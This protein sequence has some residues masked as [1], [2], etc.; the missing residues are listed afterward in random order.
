MMVGAGPPRKTKEFTSG[1]ELEKKVK[2]KKDE[3]IFDEDDLGATRKDFKDDELD[4]LFD[5]APSNP[6]EPEPEP[7]PP[8]KAKVVSKPKVKVKEPSP[9]PSPPPEPVKPKAKPKAKKVVKE[10]KKPS[11]NIFDDSDSDDMFSS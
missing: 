4:N 1:P 11:A 3:S 7:E 5:E 9:S 10:K 8:V 6:T 2:K